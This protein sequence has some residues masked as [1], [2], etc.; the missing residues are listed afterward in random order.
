MLAVIPCVSFGARARLGTAGGALTPVELI[1]LRAIGAGLDEVQSITDALGIG[2]RPVLDLIYDFWLKGYVV[3]DTEQKRVRLAG[4]AAKA[5]VSGTL[6]RLATAE[7]S[8]QVVPLVQ[9]LISGAVLPHVGR[10]HPVGPPSALIPTLRLGLALE[11]ATRSE[12]LDAVQRE[13]LRQGE[14]A[15]RPMAVH[16]AW[17]E[18]D[19]LLVE[20]DAGSGLVQQRRFLPILLDIEQ[21]SD[22]GVL[23]FEVVDAPEVPPSIRVEIARKLGAL[24]ERLASH[25]FFRKVRADLGAASEDGLASMTSDAVERLGRAVAALH[26]TDPGVVLQRH[27]QL[28]SLYDEAGAEVRARAERRASVRPVLGYEAH[29]AAIRDLLVTAERQLVLGNPWVRLSALL[30][31]FP[32]SSKSWFDLM[33]Q[34]LTRGVEVF[35]LWGIRQDEKLDPEVCN[36]LADLSAKYPNRF[37]FSQRSSTLHAKF[38]VR[39][40]HEAV[41]TSYNFL[42]PPERRDSLEVGLRIDGNPA[43]TSPHAVLSLLDWAR[44]N[45]PDYETGRRMLLRPEELG[46]RELDVEP[47]RSAPDVPDTALSGGSPIGSAPSIRHW[48][49]EWKAAHRDLFVARS[50]A[51]D[52]VDLVIDLEH[53]EALWNALRGCSRR[54]M[55]LSDKL[56]VDVVTD[57]FTQTLED[58][59][60]SGVRCAIVFRREGASDSDNGPASR[61]RALAG[62][63]EDRFSLVGA[64]SHAKVLVSDDEITIGSFNFLSYGGESAGTGRRERAE[65]SLRARGDGVIDAVLNALAAEWPDAV[66]LVQAHR[67]DVVGPVDS[68]LPSRL[69]SLFRDIRDGDPGEKFLRW[70]ATTSTPWADLEALRDAGLESSL[71]AQ[72]AAAAIA[73]SAEIE[74]DAVARWRAWLA[75]ER[76]RELDFVGTS[77]LLPSSDRGPLGVTP[78]LARLAAAV[79]ARAV[80]EDVASSA[81]EGGDEQDRAAIALLTVSILELG[82]W[83]ALAAMDELAARLPQ[84]YR[85]WPSAIR[86]YYNATFQPLP[87]ALLRRKSG[88]QAQRDA[89]EGAR[90]AFASALASAESVGFTFPIGA[91]TWSLLKSRGQLLGELRA[92]LAGGD[93][94]ALRGYLQRLDAAGNGPEELMD[95]ASQTVRDE[96]NDRIRQS[97]RDVCIARLKAACT[98]ARAWIDLSTGLSTSAGDERVLRACWEL[99]RSLADLATGDA[100]G[101]VKPVWRFARERL[102]PLFE[103]EE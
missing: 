62:R 78:W 82:N 30:D 59:L 91:R 89:I 94:D 70:F 41:V 87:M 24:S 68:L 65:V 27:N 35:L 60:R 43:G 86:A 11:G 81:P 84:R 44:S 61:L 96:H 51:S 36:A 2:Q 71:L 20:G 38:V 3:V 8:I 16:E 10:P 76:W 25:L 7:N 52:G 64:R 85:D 23:R 34:A 102:A 77:I 100:T 45:F 67:E 12:I 5:H 48:E 54:L 75:E 57:R 33:Q 88:E 56:S 92:A 58:R 14:R 18:P 74:G 72:A 98:A 83:D 103:A 42:A 63:H 1:T 46:A 15:G 101:L 97:K 28:L 37:L 95:A 22:S 9:E 79:Q 31:P 39:D 73:G 21:D 55:I 53:R 26:E 40:A 19:Q 80:P 4:E 50:K 99:R 69:Q 32:G 90:A 66:R 93:A 47:M 6:A 13:V 17:V 49:A 29:E